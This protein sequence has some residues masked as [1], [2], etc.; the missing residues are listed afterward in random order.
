MSHERRSGLLYVQRSE[1]SFSSKNVA[2]KNPNAERRRRHSHDQGWILH[3]LTKFIVYSSVQ[4][5]QN[6]TLL[7]RAHP[8]LYSVVER[9]LKDTW[10]LNSWASSDDDVEYAPRYAS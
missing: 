10:A 9:S 2:S 4:Q 8:H 5:D 6:D 7:L 3:H 1:R